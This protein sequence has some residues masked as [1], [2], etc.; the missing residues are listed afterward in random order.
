MLLI[1]TAI[2]INQQRR[3]FTWRFSNLESCFDVLSELKRQGNK[4]LRIELICNY[5]RTILPIEAF[6]GESFSKP[7]QD[8]ILE[9]QEILNYHSE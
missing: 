9:W 3:N 8:L 1:L 4:L 6:D 5:K 7:I 2:D